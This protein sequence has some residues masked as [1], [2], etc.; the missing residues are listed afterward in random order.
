MLSADETLERKVSSIQTREAGAAQASSSLPMGL[1][2]FSF[3]GDD[4]SPA[5]DASGPRLSK[6]AAKGPQV[7]EEVSYF[8]PVEQH[9][10]R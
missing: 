9:S 8:P 4:T 2:A 5:D 3:L 7:V 6:D 10:T 1:V